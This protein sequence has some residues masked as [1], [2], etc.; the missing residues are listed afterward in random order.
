M[1]RVMAIVA[2]VCMLAASAFGATTIY[3]DN[4]FGTRDF[5]TAENWDADSVNPADENFFIG[6]S[7]S[8]S[9][10]LST[11]FTGRQLAIGVG[12]AG[13]L[14]VTAGDSTF[15]AIWTGGVSGDTSVG[16]LTMTGGVLSSDSY[17]T[18]GSFGNSL[19]SLSGSSEV[20]ANRAVVGNNT[21]NATLYMKDNAVLDINVVNANNQAYRRDFT[22]GSTSGVGRVILEGAGTSIRAYDDI[23]LKANSTFEFRLDGSLGVGASIATGDLITLS[24]AI[25]ASFLDEVVPGT[26]TVLSTSATYAGA[27]VDNTSGGLISPQ[28]IDAGWSY[29]IVTT[30]NS[31]ELQLTMV[32]EPM[33]LVLLGLG[34][35]LGLR[36]RK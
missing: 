6:M 5:A 35:V 16:N 32:P 1:A 17:L 24:G 15:G 31:T 26:Y 8:D 34:G 3:W 28:M 27:I 9:P 30:E 12:A 11:S 25:E 10:I 29:E 18:M 20:Y 33:T 21:A 13:E 36:R 7:S 4:E 23:T 22:V 19:V 14:T 2:A